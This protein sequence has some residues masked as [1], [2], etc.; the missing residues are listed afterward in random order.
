MIDRRPEGIAVSDGVPVEPSALVLP[1]TDPAAQWGLGVFETIA[2]RGGTARQVPEHLRRLAAAAARMNVPLPEGGALAAAI[3]QV[4]SGIASGRGWV[5]IAVSRSGRFAAFGGSADPEETGRSISAIILPWRR[6]RL[7]PLAGIKVLAY[8]GQARG[9]E[10]AQRR[11]AE[12]G[13]WLNDRG[14]LIG[15]CTAN[16]FA[17]RG[18]AAVTPPVSDGARPGVTR[19][20]AIAAL[21]RFG[22]QVRES[23]LRVMALRAADE[24][25]LTSAVAGV[26][27]VVRLDGKDVRAGSAGPVTR[28]LAAELDAADVPR[29]PATI[30]PGGA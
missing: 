24:I 9:L 30:L 6:H 12:E 14:H 23:R 21:R 4:A 10:E 7:D 1:W 16:V 5:K 13:L 11:G 15:A 28:R 22:L 27:P 26:R 18:R 3:D 19:E 17:V 8:A 29:D 2:L 25:F 20:R